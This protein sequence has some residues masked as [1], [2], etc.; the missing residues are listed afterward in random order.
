MERLRIRGILLPSLVEVSTIQSQTKAAL[1]RVVFFCY[2]NACRSQMAE[3]YARSLGGEVLEPA[4]A[5]LNPLGFIPR[6]VGLVMEEE[7]LSIA[8][9][10]SKSLEEAQG[11]R[12][13]LIVDLAGC[14]PENLAGVVVRSRPVVD[15]FGGS[16]D[17]YRKTRDTVR[18][19]V[20][21]LIDELGRAPTPGSLPG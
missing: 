21:A 13:A 18:C 20:E 17:D 7:G 10:R 14:L 2:A 6:E 19:E 12:A 15:C 4:S 16:L 9:Q 5:G 1:P 3:A 11:A 8:G